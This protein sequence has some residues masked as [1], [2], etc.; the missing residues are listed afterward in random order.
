[1]IPLV[2][3]CEVVN[4]CN[5]DNPFNNLSSELSDG[6]T[7]IGM[8]FWNRGPPPLGGTFDNPRDFDFCESRDS[9]F[10]AEICA[11]NNDV[12]PDNWHN[13][14]GSPVQS[15]G[16]MATQCT[17]F[18]PDGSPFT[19]QVGAGTYRATNQ[20]QANEIAA[21]FACQLATVNKVCMSAP[22]PNACLNDVFSRTIT[23]TGHGPFTF[24]LIG[25]SLPP[26]ITLANSGNFTASLTGVP[27][28]TG[29]YTFT[30]RAQNAAGN[31]MVK[32]Y[33]ISVMGISPVT[34]PDGATGTDYSQQLSGVAGTS[35]YSFVLFDG[36]LPD[37]LMLSASGLI[38]G[39]PTVA[40]T[41]AFTVLMSDAS[42]R[43]CD[44]DFEIIVASGG[45]VDWNAL[46]WDAPVFTP[47]VP[48]SGSGSATLNGANFTCDVAI[49]VPDPFQ[50]SFPV[51]DC[52]GQLNLTNAL[53]CNCNLH[54]DVINSGN[55]DGS[56]VITQNGVNVLV[57]PFLLN[58]SFDLP[59]TI[60]PGVGALIEVTIQCYMASAGSLHLA[61]LLTALP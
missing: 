26:G 36:A 10:A 37:G 48:V 24:T 41:F 54:I 44:Q 4:P 22:N 52:H 57:Q 46:I 45:C 47:G 16:N 23:A 38:S 25:G 32:T 31:F 19:Y 29:N 53:P 15:Y 1:M 7:F 3:P 13:P 39:T 12:P 59:F 5:N 49:G 35:P 20:A 30:I 14:D 40:D 28:A 11:K 42:G 50:V 43:A 60:P 21:S 6:P 27:T 2:F 8:D 18:C 58:G 55:G 56:I 33:T 51:V 34:L 17:V 61:G 9:Q